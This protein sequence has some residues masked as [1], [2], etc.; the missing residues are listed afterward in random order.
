MLAFTFV[1]VAIAVLGALVL[2]RIFSEARSGRAIWTSAALAI[3]VQLATYGVARRYA[4]RGDALKGW[5]IGAIIRVTVLVLYGL[6]F[7]GP[8]HVG[9]PL[10]PALLSFA[11]FVFAS[12]LV[13]PL[14]LSR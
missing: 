13:E 8:W 11:V 9:L 7:F 14:F 1:T 4:S 3:A 6:L 10:E 5:G 2:S 12:M